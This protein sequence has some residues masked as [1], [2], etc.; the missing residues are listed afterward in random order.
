VPLILGPGFILGW[1]FSFMILWPITFRICAKIN[2]APFA[3]K[4]TVKVLVGKYKNS[5]GRVAGILFERGLIEVDLEIDSV[6]SSRQDSLG[7]LE[8]YR[9]NEVLRI[10][11]PKKT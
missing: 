6:N 4:D 2:G 5:C 9:C 11:D 10:K 1:I 8:F 3:I 7:V